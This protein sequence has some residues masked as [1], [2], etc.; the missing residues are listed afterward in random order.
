MIPKNIKMGQELSP[1]ESAEKMDGWGNKPAEASC[2]AA[3]AWPFGCNLN[4]SSILRIMYFR[5]RMMA[6]ADRML[7]N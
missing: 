2:Q 1:F 7:Y 5:V 4:T 6:K 3:A